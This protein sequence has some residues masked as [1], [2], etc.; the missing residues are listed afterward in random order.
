MKVWITADSE[1]MEREMLCQ[2]K[3]TPE[4]ARKTI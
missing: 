4:N 2:G 3:T 1:N